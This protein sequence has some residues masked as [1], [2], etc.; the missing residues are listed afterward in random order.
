ME[1]S[2]L[3]KELKAHAKVNLF[4]AVGKTDEKNYHMLNTVFQPLDLSDKII[5]EERMSKG[6]ALRSN[7][8]IPLGEKNSVHKAVSL[9]CQ[10]A[11]KSIANARLN[12]FIHKNIPLSSGLGGSAVD[13]APVIRELNSRWNVGLADNEMEVIAS[14]VGADVPQA[15]HNDATYAE[16]YGDEI[17]SHYSLPKKY[18][19]IYVPRE[20]MSEQPAKTA[21][22]YKM[23][24]AER[25]EKRDEA[26]RMRKCLMKKALELKNWHIIGKL[27]H[28][29]FEFVAFK[30]YP[31][32]R[33][34]KELFLEN[35]AHGALLAGSGGAVFG[36]F[37]TPELSFKASNVV[38]SFVGMSEFGQ[39]IL[40]ETL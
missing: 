39:I 18:V 26:V 15:L 13:A 2:N 5:L 34:V 24:D 33:K 40:T 7:W 38:H 25:N 31:L 12:I 11:E 16:R 32:L 8:E 4:L 36:V 27:M 28:N 35:G 21:A 20:Y 19:C 10:E 17:L 3:R 23:I 22:L 37:E 14:M 1:L 9:M 6:V 30:K 29:D